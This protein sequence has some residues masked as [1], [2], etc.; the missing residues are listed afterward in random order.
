MSPI[1]CNVYYQVQVSEVVN[2]HLQAQLY[3]G[4]MADGLP[5]CTCSR[6]RHIHMGSEETQ[7][8]DD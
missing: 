4:C 6:R 5:S 7:R 2:W 1:Y 8:Q 3:S